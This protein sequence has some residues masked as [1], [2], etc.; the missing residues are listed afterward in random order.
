[1][2]FERRMSVGWREGTE[3]QLGTQRHASGVRTDDFSLILLLLIQLLLA[4]IV[5]FVLIT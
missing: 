3:N 5:I 4:V 2:L 1:M